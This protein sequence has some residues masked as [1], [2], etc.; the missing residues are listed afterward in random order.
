M[1]ARSRSI[2]DSVP[3]GD[4]EVA[5][6]GWRR[7]NRRIDNGEGVFRHFLAEKQSMT[8]IA[9]PASRLLAEKAFSGPSRSN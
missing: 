1:G 7:S 8:T 5:N 3:K 9:C 6:G 2:F 4:H